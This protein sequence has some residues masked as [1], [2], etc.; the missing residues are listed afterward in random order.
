MHDRRK[1]LGWLMRL[2]YQLF[3]YS[4]AP[5]VCEDPA[6]VA[7]PLHNVTMTVQG[8]T[9]QLSCLFKGNLDHLDTSLTSYWRI[10]F[11]P[12]Q[13]YNGSL[14]VDDNSTDLYRIAVYQTCSGTTC[15]TFINQLVILDAPLSLNDA[16]LTCTESLSVAGSDKPVEYTSNTTICKLNDI[17]VVKTMMVKSLAN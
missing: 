16:T 2:C 3:V 10:N 17:Y 14:Y 6:H 9:I 7:I 15:C 13:Q 5:M 4:L 1:E 11:P 8:E 12:S